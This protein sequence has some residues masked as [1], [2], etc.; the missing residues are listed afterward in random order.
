MKEEASQQ[1]HRQIE[2]YLNALQLVQQ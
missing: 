1:E 2:S